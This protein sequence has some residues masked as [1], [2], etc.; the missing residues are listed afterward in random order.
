MEIANQGKNL[1]V[2]A[3]TFDNIDPEGLRALSAYLSPWDDVVIV[4]YYRRYY[5]YT[6]S[7]YNQWVKERKLAD[8]T[9]WTASIVDAIIGIDKVIPLGY[10]TEVVSRVRKYFDNVVTINM[11]DDSQRDNIE[12]FSL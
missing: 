10:T 8:T 6:I 9:K 3:E 2:S 4:I 7:F 5:D 11:H 12:K 1:L